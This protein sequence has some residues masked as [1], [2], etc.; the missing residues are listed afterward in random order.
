MTSVDRRKLMPSEIEVLRTVIADETATPEARRDA[1]TH[2]V[3]LQVD[4]VPDASPDDP[5]VVKLVTPWEDRQLASWF[6]VT[7]RVRSLAEAVA[8]VTE[9]HRW[10]AR[11]RIVANEG[12]SRT[13]RLAACQS[14]LDHMSPQ[15]VFRLNAYSAAKLLEIVKPDSAT[16]YSSLAGGRVPVQRPPVERSDVWD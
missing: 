6:P 10:R 13:E 2:A 14:V 5:E 11:Y 3:R 1:A 8:E 7:S 4:A 9:Q 16:K 12:L 15:S